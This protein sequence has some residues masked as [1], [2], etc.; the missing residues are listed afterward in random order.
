MSQMMSKTVVTFAFEKLSEKDT[1]KG[2]AP[3][4]GDIPNQPVHSG[5]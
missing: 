3:T 2:N 4:V 1:G 5:N